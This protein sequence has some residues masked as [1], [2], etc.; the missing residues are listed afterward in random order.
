MDTRSEKISVALAFFAEP[1]ID[2]LEEGMTQLELDSILRTASSVWNA[3]VM[4]ENAGTESYVAEVRGLSAG[5]E[6]P[7]ALI[8]FLIERKQTEFAADQRMIGEPQAIWK[9]GQWHIRATA[10]SPP[11]PSQSGSSI[12]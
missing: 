4:D 6:G 1:L 11:D 9:D 2:E 12:H 5:Q 7:A 8:E 10:Y 3:C